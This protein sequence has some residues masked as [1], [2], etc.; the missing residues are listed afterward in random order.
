MPPDQDPPAGISG[1]DAGNGAPETR[2]VRREKRDRK[3]KEKMARHGG[4][5]GQ[6]YRDAVLKKAK[7]KPS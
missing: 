1:E 6:V 3:K 2:Q 4:G 7:T 5:L